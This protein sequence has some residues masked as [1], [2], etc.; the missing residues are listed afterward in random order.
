MG[1]CLCKKIA[2]VSCATVWTYQY[3]WLLQ[4]SYHRSE[5]ISFWR[6]LSDCRS[7]HIIIVLLMLFIVFDIFHTFF[8]KNAYSMLFNH[9]CCVILI[10]LAALHDGLVT[11]SHGSAIASPH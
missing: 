11:S 7:E 9:K 1:V 10:A 6:R 2:V 8:V 5:W 4:I 3:K